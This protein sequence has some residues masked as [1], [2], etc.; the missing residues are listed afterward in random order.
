MKETRCNSILINKG[1]SVVAELFPG[2]SGIVSPISWPWGLYQDHNT[3]V[4]TA[5][6]T[7]LFTPN[8]L[9]KEKGICLHSTY[10]NFSQNP[11][12]K[13]FVCL[14]VGITHAFIVT[15]WRVHWLEI[16][17]ACCIQ[18]MARTQP[19]WPAQYSGT[20]QGNGPANCGNGDPRT[21]WAGK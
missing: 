4:Q 18:A 8:I 6:R 19:G 11:N 1:L 15:W 9:N 16:L 17:P 7:S 5:R 10:A 21:I 12:L 14:I 2:I 13:L 20:V 3:L